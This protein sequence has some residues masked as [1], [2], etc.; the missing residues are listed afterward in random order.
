MRGRRGHG[1]AAAPW[2]E[3]PRKEPWRPDRRTGWAPG[4][5]PGPTPQGSCSER[6]R[7]E[8]TSV[9]GALTS[10]CGNAPEMKRQPAEPKE[11]EEKIL[12]MQ[13]RIY[14]SYILSWPKGFR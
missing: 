3:R 14:I 5:R 10:R 9:G 4:P 6:I 13:E 11:K 12:S 7:P 8:G 1:S 2:P